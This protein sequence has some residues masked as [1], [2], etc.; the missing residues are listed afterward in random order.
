M[1]AAANGAAEC[2]QLLLQNGADIA[3]NYRDTDGLSAVM[4]AAMNGQPECLSLLLDC[5]AEI[6]CRCHEKKWTALMKAAQRGTPRHT[7]CV[8]L[9]LSIGA[10]VEVADPL[11]ETAAMI[12]AREGR[13]ES[14]AV[15]VQQNA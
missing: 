10:N 3:V 2:L 11:G 5:G 8:E 4:H 9:L 14:L 12:A 6:E 1:L 13:V 7:E 15:C